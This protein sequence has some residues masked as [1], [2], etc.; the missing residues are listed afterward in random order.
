VL[1]T[2]SN[3]TASPSI[4]RSTSHNNPASINRATSDTL[5]HISTADNSASSTDVSALLYGA[6]VATTLSAE[7]NCHAKNVR[8]ILNAWND[9]TL[10]AA[11]SVKMSVKWLLTT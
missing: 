9:N 2:T 6:P 4:G 7:T 1:A 11:E 5:F 3:S 10:D 8:D